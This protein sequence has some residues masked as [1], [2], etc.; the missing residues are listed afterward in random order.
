MKKIITLVLC[1]VLVLAMVGCGGKIADNVNRVVGYSALYDEKLINEAFDAIED[2][3]ASEFD[4]CTLTELKYDA[5]IENKFADEIAKYNK[6]HEQDKQELIIVV[7]TFD[8]DVKGGDGSFN[9]NET[10]TNWQWHLVR[11]LGKN[12]WEIISWGY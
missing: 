2:K 3:F 9:S 8:T 4:G 1:L 5:D 10:Y 7:S 11:T 6:D 12:G